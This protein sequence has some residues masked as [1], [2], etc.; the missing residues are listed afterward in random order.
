M[1]TDFRK[2]D[3]LPPCCVTH[4]HTHTHSHTSQY[5]G[6]ELDGR[7]L[8]ALDGV[9]LM[10]KLYYIPD[11][12]LYLHSTVTRGFVRFVRCLFHRLFVSEKEAIQVYKGLHSSLVNFLDSLL[13]II[14]NL[15][16]IWDNWESCGVDGSIISQAKQSTRMYSLTLWRVRVTI[17]AVGKAIPITYSKCVCVCSLIIQDAMRMLRIILISVARLVA[18]PYFSTLSHKWDVFPGK[19]IGQ[20]ICVLFFP[21]NFVW[22]ISH[23]KNYWG[24]YD[25]NCVLVVM[26]GTRYSCHIGMKLE[27]FDIFSKNTQI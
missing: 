4:T 5:S 16:Y 10:F 22:I 25:Q 2:F 14:P 7:R 21:I 20:E 15:I 3:F 24:K 8:L 6:K 1:W 18:V 9:V 26:Y 13:T 12:I 27:F 11:Q 23:S 17:A 19:G